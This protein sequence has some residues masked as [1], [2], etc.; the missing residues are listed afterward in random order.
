VLFRKL[1]SG[2]C[3]NKDRRTF[4]QAFDRG[5][6]LSKRLKAAELELA[7]YVEASAIA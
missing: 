5:S 3:K 7:D 2:E 4:T 1:G 6:S